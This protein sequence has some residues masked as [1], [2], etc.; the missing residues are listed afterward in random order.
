MVSSFRNKMNFGDFLIY[1]L[2]YFGLFTTIYF[3]I[4]IQKNKKEVYPSKNNYFPF[5]DQ[6]TAIS[7]EFFKIYFKITIA[8]GGFYGKYI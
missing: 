4:T 7:K 1:V 8:V 5:N 6:N 3:L 2:S